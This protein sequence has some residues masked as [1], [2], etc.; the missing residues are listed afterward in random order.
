MTVI[1]YLHVNVFRVRLI[2]HVQFGA[3]WIV[4]ADV[5]TTSCFMAFYDILAPHHNHINENVF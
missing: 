5:I 3:D 4:Y 1:Q 2:I